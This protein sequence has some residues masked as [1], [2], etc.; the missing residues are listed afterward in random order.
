MHDRILARELGAL[1]PR[2]FART[3]TTEL[4]SDFDLAQH[5][6]FDGVS[7]AAAGASSI[8]ERAHDTPIVAHNGGAN[9]VAIEKFDGKL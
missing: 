8:P 6:R 7:A 9:T 3:V 4:I 1:S 2:D 5:H